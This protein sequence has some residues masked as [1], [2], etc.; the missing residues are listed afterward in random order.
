MKKMLVSGGLLA[1][2]L[3]AAFTCSQAL[4]QI[5]HNDE[6]VQRTGTKLTLGGED[7]RYSGPEYR[8][9]G[10]GSLWTPRSHWAPLSI[11]L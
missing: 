3:T 6:F 10:R 8:V 9:A 5:A 7:F 1:V 2:A 4:A 11:A